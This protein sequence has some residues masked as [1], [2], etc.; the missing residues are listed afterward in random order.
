MLQKS[1]VLDI[2]S[3]TI[4]SV[5]FVATLNLSPESIV[6]KDTTYWSACGKSEKMTAWEGTFAPNLKLEIETVQI[7]PVL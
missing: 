3:W 6:A 4:I 5:P 7:F 1:L 2:A